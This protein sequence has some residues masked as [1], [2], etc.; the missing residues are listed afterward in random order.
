MKEEEDAERAREDARRAEGAFPL[1]G[2]NAQPGPVPSSVSAQKQPQRQPQS[3]AHKVLSL[4]SKT[5]KVTMASY[6]PAPALQSYSGQAES[7]R[8]VEPKP[9]RVPPPPPRDISSEPVRPWTELNGRRLMYQPD[10]A[11]EA[12]RRKALRKEKKRAETA[13]ASS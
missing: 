13:S 11:V 6:T 7:A 5:K 8:E 12:E 2:M 3:Q 4:N 1:L 10:P 9:V